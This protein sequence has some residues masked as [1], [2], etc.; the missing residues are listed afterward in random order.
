MFSSQTDNSQH[1]HYGQI[2]VVVMCA[3]LLILISIMKSPNLKPQSLALDQYLSDYQAAI[4]ETQQNGSNSTG[5]TLTAAPVNNTVASSNVQKGISLLG[6]ITKTVVSISPPN[7]AT[8]VFGAAVL[9][10][11]RQSELISSFLQRNQFTSV[12]FG[13][14][15]VL[16]SNTS[17]QPN[18][19]R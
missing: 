15:A 9:T 16:G 12:N 2:G 11:L 18:S 10:S 6:Q 3:S 7:F 19:L 13:S 1:F 8:A 14:Y 4:K 17:R 5:E